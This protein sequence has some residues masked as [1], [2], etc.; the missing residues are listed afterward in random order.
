MASDQAYTE[1]KSADKKVQDLEVKDA[2]II[3]N[4][5]WASLEDE[6]GEEYLRFPKEIFWLNATTCGQRSAQES[7]STEDERRWY[8]SGRS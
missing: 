7:G 8:A 3:F 6:L 4:S 1:I 5:V 2:Q